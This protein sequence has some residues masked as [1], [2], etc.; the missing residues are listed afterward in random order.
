MKLK[1]FA[2]FCLFLSFSCNLQ[3]G[4]IEKELS[5][6]VQSFYENKDDYL[7]FTE[8]LKDAGLL[9]K[10]NKLELL[11]LSKLSKDLQV[12][13]EKLG[14]RKIQYGRHLT[15]D[16][17]LDDSREV[18]FYLEENIAIWYCACSRQSDKEYFDNNFKLRG[19][20]GLIDFYSIGLGWSF[21][22]AK[23]KN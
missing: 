19:Y 22:M 4:K 5:P 3:R 16:A 6:Y 2:F 15:C 1:L 7:S 11:D 8:A 21:A 9:L 20:E 13:L 12:Q 18:F 14:I 10:S 23:I 17:M